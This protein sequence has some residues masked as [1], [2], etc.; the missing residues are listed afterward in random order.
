MSKKK[1]ERTYELDYVNS[2]EP[3]PY[4]ALFGLVMTCA[5]SGIMIQ[6]FNIMSQESCNTPLC[7]VGNGVLFIFGAATIAI[8]LSILSCGLFHT[9][10]VLVE[11]VDLEV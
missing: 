9:R 4:E 11:R 8:G 5:G 10:Q 7:C 6:L 3:N 1:E 2:Y